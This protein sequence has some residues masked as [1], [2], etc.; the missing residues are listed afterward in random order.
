LHYF[1]LNCSNYIHGVYKHKNQNTCDIIRQKSL[2]TKFI[3]KYISPFILQYNNYPLH[4]IWVLDNVFKKHPSYIFYSWYFKVH[5]SM[6]EYLLYHDYVTTNH[7]RI[8]YINISYSGEITILCV[9][10]VKIVPTSVNRVYPI[11]QNCVLRNWKLFQLLLT[12][13]IK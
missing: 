6:M 2:K 12:V 7:E 5:W 11:T 9:E 4:C 1:G 13:N 8:I 3:K 10:E